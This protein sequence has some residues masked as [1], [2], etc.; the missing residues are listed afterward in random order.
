MGYI[1]ESHQYEEDLNAALGGTR[2]RP[3]VMQNNNINDDSNTPVIKES[4]KSVPFKQK[5]KRNKYTKT[6]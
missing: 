3:Q 4:K 5:K 1:R 6:K 2:A